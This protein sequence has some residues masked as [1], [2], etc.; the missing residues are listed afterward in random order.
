MLRYR[1]YATK[2]RLVLP[3]HAEKFE[4]V[5]LAYTVKFAC[6]LL[7][8]AAKFD[9]EHLT[10]AGTSILVAL[11]FDET[12]KPVPLTSSRKSIPDHQP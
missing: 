9:I 12:S 11:S 1:T 8:C 2:S 6:E 10:S 5:P 7:I 3:L 4:L